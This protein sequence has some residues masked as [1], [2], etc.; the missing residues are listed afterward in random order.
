MFTQPTH[1]LSLQSDDPTEARA[2]APSPHPSQRGSRLASRAGECWAAP[3]LCVAISPLCPPHPCCCA[4]LHG[5]EASPLCQLQSL[6]TKGLPSVWKP[7]LLHSSLPLV[8][9]PSLF[10]CL[11]FFLFCFALPSYVGSFLPFG[12][13]EVFC[14]RSMSVL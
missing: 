13:S 14:Q 1:V 10:F 4:L 5:S 9:V 11:C 7:F 6:P 3:L 12:R 8:Q 2:L